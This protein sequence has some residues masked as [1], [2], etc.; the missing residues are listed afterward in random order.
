M[1]KRR[2][3]PATTYAPPAGWRLPTED[4]PQADHTAGRIDLGATYRGNLT[5]VEEAEITA[6]HRPIKSAATEAAEAVARESMPRS[7]A[8]CREDAYPMALHGRAIDLDGKPDWTEAF[9]RVLTGR[10]EMPPLEARRLGLVLAEYALRHPTPYSMLRDRY[11]RDRSY[12]DMAR[13]LHIRPDTVAALV[14][15]AM[16]WIA[17]RWSVLYPPSY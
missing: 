12:R 9:H 10:D 3:D 1:A 6:G 16:L 15:G 14:E 11:E 17:E 13:E 8:R 4:S 2:R 5:S 7:T